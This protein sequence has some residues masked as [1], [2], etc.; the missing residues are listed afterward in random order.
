MKK[1]FIVLIALLVTIPLVLY[2]WWSQALK[3]VDPTNTEAV[4]FTIESGEDSRTISDK[5]FKAN[6]IRS[7]VAFYLL[8]RFGGYGRKIQAGEFH[9]TPSMS[10]HEI[11][12]SLTIGTMDVWITIPEGWRREE[13][14]LKLAKELNI[15]ETEFLKVAKE[16]YLF[17]ET[18]QVQ[19]EATVSVIISMFQNEF[20]KK[21]TSDIFSKAQK[22]QL[23]LDELITIASL[24]ER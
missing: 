18:Y 5:L 9:L 10:M 12:N 1:R 23:T 15:P 11:A 3:P 21:I 2:M 13:I 14:A 20:N 22:R 8:S 24:V 4:S 7:P 6:L 19:K 17:P 16:G